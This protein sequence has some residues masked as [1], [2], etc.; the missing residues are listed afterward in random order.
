MLETF[1]K[2]TAR[3]LVLV[4]YYPSAIPDPHTS[5]PI[6]M[7]VLVHLAG[8]EVGV[9]RNPEVLGIQAKRR[10]ITK[11]IPEGTG[12]GGMLKLAYP[13]YTYENVEPGFAEHDL[14]E[15]DKVSARLA[16]TRSLDTV[17]KAF[18]AEVNLEKVWDDHVDCK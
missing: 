11:R 17:R 8:Q 5:F 10:T 3:L 16:W 4:A 7:R 13:S 12:V 6:G 18:R 9:N 2:Q 1:R 15:Y 14:E